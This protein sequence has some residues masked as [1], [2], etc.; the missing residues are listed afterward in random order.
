MWGTLNQSLFFATMELLSCFM[1]HSMT[2][3]NL[4][5]LDFC[6]RGKEN[7]INIEVVRF[8]SGDKNKI[9]EQRFSNL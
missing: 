9:N 7:H 1:V 4:S 8:P 2:N 3:G 6:L 5:V